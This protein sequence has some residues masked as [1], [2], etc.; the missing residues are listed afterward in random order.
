MPPGTGD[1]QITLTQ[2]I[3]FT[4]AVIVTTP[5]ILAVADVLKGVEMFR[6]LR[7]PTLAVVSCYLAFSEA[8]NPAAYA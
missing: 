3:A 6:D 8:S 1:I 7:V 5:H 2:S 4:G